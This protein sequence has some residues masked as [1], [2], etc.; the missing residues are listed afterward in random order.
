MRWAVSFAASFSGAQWLAIGMIVLSSLASLSY[1][2][3]GDVRRGIY[4]AAVA[5]ITAVVTF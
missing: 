3:Q 4:W 2:Y 5:L 1:F